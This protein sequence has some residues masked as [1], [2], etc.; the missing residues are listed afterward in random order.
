MVFLTEA[1]R[2]EEKDL[3]YFCRKKEEKERECSSARD[4]SFRVPEMSKRTWQIPGGKV[5]ML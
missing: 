3:E 1:G 2:V 5:A 4:E